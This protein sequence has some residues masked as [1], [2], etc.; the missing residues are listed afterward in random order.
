MN[1][2]FYVDKKRK[3]S[4]IMCYASSPYFKHQFSTGLKVPLKYIQF[5]GKTKVK[6]FSRYYK[7]RYKVKSKLEQ[8]ENYIKD[9]EA[10]YPNLSKND[11]IQNVNKLRNKDVK[12]SGTFDLLDWYTELSIKMGR[13]DSTIKVIRVLTKHIKVFLDSDTHIN[14]L[15]QY[16]FFYNFKEYLK[17]Q[18]LTQNSI[19]LYL[20]ISKAIMNTFVRHKIIKEYDWVNEKIAK[21]KT[22]KHALN[23]DE[24]YKIANIQLNNRVLENARYWF[25]IQCFTGVRK[26][27]LSKIKIKE[28]AKEIPLITQ[29][30][31]TLVKIPVLQPL[32]RFLESIPM[33]KQAEFHRRGINDAY[34]SYLRR[35]AKIAE[36]DRIVEIVE[37]HNG[38]RTVVP[39]E[40]YTQLSSHWARR[41]FITQAI[42]RGVP[43]HI[44]MAVTGHKTVT[45]LEGYI[46]LVDSD[47][48]KTFNEAF[49]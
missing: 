4:F 46:K 17:S 22:M 27:D 18:G 19:S 11:F 41:T 39:K 38:V 8:L 25:I 31:K 32:K 48:N 28:N 12:N 23:E 21:T 33:N 10:K 42:I 26:C 15:Q 45:T 16:N 24:I 20:R 30:T 43:P 13:E 2:T 34:N 44:I 35:I 3:E 9:I 37:E 29:K 36:L 14:T 40:L 6:G 7:D 5:D 47:V 1:L 49:S